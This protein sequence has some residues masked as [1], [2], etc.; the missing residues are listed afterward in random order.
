[1]SRSQGLR[2]AEPSEEAVR[3]QTAGR[4]CPDGPV[5]LFVFVFLNM[6][7]CLFLDSLSLG[8]DFMKETET[9]SFCSH[10]G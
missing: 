10:Q 2:L 7:K 4:S 8:L 5:C 9:F 6:S 1:M 3:P